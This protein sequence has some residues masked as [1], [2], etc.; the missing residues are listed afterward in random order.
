MCVDGPAGRPRCE[1]AKRLLLECVQPRPVFFSHVAEPS[2]L[3]TIATDFDALIHETLLR[4]YDLSP[5]ELSQSHVAQLSRSSARGGC[6]LQPLAVRLEYNF[7]DGA[8]SVAYLISQLT[9]QAFGET[10]TPYERVW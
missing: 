7:V 5:A 6:G 2:G 4:I 1:S 3:R 8:T 9:G 10:D